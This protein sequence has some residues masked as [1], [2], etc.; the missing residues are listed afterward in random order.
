MRR[1]VQSTCAFFRSGL[2]SYNIKNLKEEIAFLAYYFHWSYKEI[3][4]LSH[5]ERISY[6]EEVSKINKKLNGDENRKNIFDV[7]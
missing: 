7:F 5:K 6:C 1:K 4:E 3:T 2:K